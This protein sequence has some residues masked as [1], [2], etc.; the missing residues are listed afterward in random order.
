VVSAVLDTKKSWDSYSNTAP[1]PY[2]ILKV[3]SGT[4]QTKTISDTYTPTWNQDVL[5]ATAGNLLASVSIEVY[6]EDYGYDQLIGSCTAAVTEKALL[7]GEG[8][9]QP[10]SKWVTKITFK[11]SSK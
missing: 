6:D 11:F 1:D 2:V 8:S 10:C 4:G 7:A 3:A 9:L 5:T